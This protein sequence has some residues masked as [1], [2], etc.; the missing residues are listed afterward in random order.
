MDD[1]LTPNGVEDL[2]D[3]QNETDSFAGD[4]LS[5]DEESSVEPTRQTL[6]LAPSG[7]DLQI[8]GVAG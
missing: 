8:S 6:V 5:T 3:A 7:F 1:A 4:A 2:T